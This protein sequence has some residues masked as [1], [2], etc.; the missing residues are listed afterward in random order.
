M[1]IGFT[2]IEISPTMPDM[3]AEI[4]FLLV[5]SASFPVIIQAQPVVSNN[6]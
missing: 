4:L 3:K 2:L 6:F 1:D 5:L